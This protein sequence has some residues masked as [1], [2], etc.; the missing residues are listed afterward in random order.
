MKYPQFIGF[1][2]TIDSGQSF[3]SNGQNDFKYSIAVLYPFL[4][5]HMSLWELPRV[6]LHL[7]IQALANAEFNNKLLTDNFYFK[8]QLGFHNVY[9]CQILNNSDGF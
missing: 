3:I 7:S 4:H 8:A 5:L 9:I 2:Y 6:I 1:E